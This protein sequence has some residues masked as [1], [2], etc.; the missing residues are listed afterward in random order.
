MSLFF[1]SPLDIEIRLDGEDSRELV[2]VRGPDKGKKVPLYL[3]GES[4]KGTVTIR[5]KDGKRLEHSGIKV[6]F[7]GCIE[8]KTIGERARAPSQARR[9][10]SVHGPGTGCSWRT[11]PP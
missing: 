4:V 11:A 5:P 7:I 10:V 2:E 8:T 3:D 1:K 6:Q 9:G